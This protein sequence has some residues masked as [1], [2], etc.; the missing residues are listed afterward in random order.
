MAH[1]GAA[2]GQESV[3]D[4]SWVRGARQGGR[5]GV[6]LPSNRGKVPPGW[7]LAAPG[8]D[9]AVVVDYHDVK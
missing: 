6:R 4:G 2:L 8:K 9:K 3:V 5:A 1:G 7:R